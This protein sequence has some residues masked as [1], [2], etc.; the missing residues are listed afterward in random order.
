MRFALK[1]S[2]VERVTERIVEGGERSEVIERW[3]LMRTRGGNW[4]LS[5]I[6]QT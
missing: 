2:M 5:A 6:Q 1:D 3:T 4:L